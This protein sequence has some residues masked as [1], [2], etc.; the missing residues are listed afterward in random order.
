MYTLRDHHRDYYNSNYYRDVRYLHEIS[1]PLFLNSNNITM[2]SNH[3]KFFLDFLNPKF[4]SGLYGLLGAE[5]S[6]YKTLDEY[7]IGNNMNRY[8]DRLFFDFDVDSEKASVI[9]KEIFDT[10][11]NLVGNKRREKIRSLQSEY[12]SL[13]FEEDLLE[14]PFK[15]AT[16]LCNYLQNKEINPYLIV[17]GSKGFH[18]NV[19][20]KEMQ[21][22]QIGHISEHLA[23]LFKKNLGLETLDLAVNKDAYRRLQRVPY[24][25][26]SKT[27]LYCQP[28]SKELSYDEVLDLIAKK[29]N[30]PVEFDICEYYAPA[31][32]N[33]LLKSLN[34]DFN[35]EIKRE[36][37]SRKL[38]MNKSTHNN[39]LFNDVDLRNLA[40]LTLGEPIAIYE[41]RNTYCCPFHDD[42]HASAATFD[43]RFYCSACGVNLNRYDFVMQV[44][45]AKTKNEMLINLKEMFNLQ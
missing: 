10:Q 13:I 25:I 9:K 12:R 21:L 1:K 15:E 41:N 30:T 38:T 43:N 18:V 45:G 20:F 27:G 34:D 3:Q 28:I 14:K 8:S 19:F 36:N 5:I 40:L 35:K 22:N 6:Y 31:T 11:S 26:N 29:D 42:N 32:F 23:T 33:D 39:D 7:K 4:H 24:S 16:K 37:K 17:S 2:I 44:T